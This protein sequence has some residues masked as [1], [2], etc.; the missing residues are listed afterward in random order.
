MLIVGRAAIKVEIFSLEALSFSINLNL[1]CNVTLVL[2]SHLL[3]ALVR[4]VITGAGRSLGAV[5]VACLCLP[6]WRFHRRNR[7]HCPRHLCFRSH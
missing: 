2:V 1:M 4:N 6:Q 5:G 7:C 3:A